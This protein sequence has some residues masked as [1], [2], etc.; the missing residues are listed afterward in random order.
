MGEIS[1]KRVW[2][3][4]YYT[5]INFTSSRVVEYNI[6]TLLCRSNKYVL[7][8]SCRKK[9]IWNK[10]LMLD[11][12]FQQNLPCFRLWPSTSKIPTL[13]LIALFRF[14]SSPKWFQKYGKFWSVSLDLCIKRK[15]LI[16]EECKPESWNYIWLPA[17]F[18]LDR[19]F[20]YYF[21]TQKFF[22]QF[23]MNQSVTSFHS[24]YFP[25]LNAFM[26]YLGTSFKKI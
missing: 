2:C 7:L 23:P 22:L 13:F 3:G 9:F 12:M 6:F 15:P 16:T 17:M 19:K 11:E 4:R 10:R 1:A 8:T 26:Y 18:L 25:S 21:E 24:I 20:L 14:L 5:Q